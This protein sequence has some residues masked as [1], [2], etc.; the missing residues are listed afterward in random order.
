[1]STPASVSPAA[2]APD[3]DLFVSHA[4][5][6][7]ESVTRLHDA[8]TRAGLNVWVDH[9]G[10]IGSSDR[11]PMQVQDALNRCKAGMYVLSRQSVRRAIAAYEQALRF[12][13][14]EAAPLDHAMTQNN[15]GIA[16]KESGDLPGAIRC[17]CAAAQYYRAMGAADKA[18]LMQQWVTDAGGQCP[19]PA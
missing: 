9:R 7:D 14:P 2:P 16:L 15:L 19:P 8:L 18:G 12:R 17:W 10:G 4:T 11:W 13:T 1:M 3:L 5:A 6:D